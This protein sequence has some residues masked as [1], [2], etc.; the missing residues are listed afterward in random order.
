MPL[1]FW[2]VRESEGRSARKPDPV[3]ATVSRHWG[4]HGCSAF[5]LRQA[6]YHRYVA[7]HVL[8]AASPGVVQSDSAAPAASVASE[9]GSRSLYR[10]PPGR[11]AWHPSRVLVRFKATASAASAA[12]VQ[13][14]SPLPGLRLTRLA[15]EHHTVPVP[16]QPSSSGTIGVASVAAS[17]GGSSSMPPDAIFVYEVTN[18]T[19]L[20]A[21]KRL[22]SNPRERSA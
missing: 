3:G 14:R 10:T 4:L 19:V 12:A 20:D 2:Q 1:H 8:G 9:A 5:H 7:G 11:P 6:S 21:V 15:G 13:A 18:G 16:S 17:T 22:R